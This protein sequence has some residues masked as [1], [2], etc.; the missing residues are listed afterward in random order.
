MTHT[1]SDPEDDPARELVARARSVAPERLRDVHVFSPQGHQDLYLRPDVED[2]LKDADL[3]QYI[4]QER[5][6]SIVAETYDSLSYTG[7]RYTV[8]GFSTFEQFRTF[9]DS[10]GTI[11]ILVSYD[12]GENSIPWNELEEKLQSVVSRVGIERIR[13]H[14]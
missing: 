10:E 13:P 2:R 14:R 9:L 5:H 3:E 1:A 8:R 6:G 12:R 11:G 4:D 7:Y